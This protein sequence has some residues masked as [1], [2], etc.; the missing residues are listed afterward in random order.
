MSSWPQVREEIL[1]L[2]ALTPRVLTGYTGPDT[3]PEPQPPFTVRLTSSS[4]AIAK[5]LHERFGDEV[6]LRVGALAYPPGSGESWSEPTLREPVAPDHVLAGLHVEL[7][8]PLEVRSGESADHALRITNDTDR[9]IT[10]RTNGQLTARIVDLRDGRHVGGASGAQRM[11][12]VTFPVAPGATT[13]IPLW[14]GTDS[15]LPALGYTIPPGPWGVTVDL[16]LTDGPTLHSPVLAF[17][18]TA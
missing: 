17:D 8:G 13:R 9:I 14:V 18:V 2:E 7:D 15:Y 12:L 1:R 3:D 11:P 6:S 4:E 10:V 16:D 5:Q